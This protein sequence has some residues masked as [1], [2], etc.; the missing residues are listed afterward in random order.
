MMV[1]KNTW[2]GI[3]PVK[4]P[5]GNGNRKT[6]TEYLTD[7]QIKLK[8]IHDSADQHTKQEQQRYVDHYNERAIDKHF[9]V[10]QQVIVLIPDS[11]KKMISRWQGPGTIIESKS[12][13]SYLVELDQSTSLV[14]C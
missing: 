10:G 13:Y 2:T 1:I 11:T 7:L 8:E 3:D 6:V 12:P 4:M 14:T 9:T 5:A